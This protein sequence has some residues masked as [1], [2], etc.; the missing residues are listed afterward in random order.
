MRRWIIGGLTCMLLAASMP[1]LA[2]T[3][4]VPVVKNGEIDNVDYDTQLWVSNEGLEGRNFISLFIE[5]NADGTDR[6]DGEYDERI[7]VPRLATVLVQEVAAPGAVGLLEL[8]TAPQLAVQARIIS[9]FQQNRRLGVSLP[10]ISSDN[11][12]EAGGMIRLEPLTRI[13]S[14]H[15]DF[16]V[17]NLGLETAQCTVSFFQ[18]NGSPLG[19][20]AVINVNPRSL[21]EFPDVLGI[22]GAE[23]LGGARSEVSCSEGF[24]AF[25]VTT[26]SSDGDV[27]VVLPSALGSSTLSRP[28]EIPDPTACVEGAD[29]FIIDGMFYRATASD[30]KRTLTVPVTK[31]TEFRR[32]YIEFDFKHGGWFPSLPDG[33]HNIL[34]LTRTG[35]YSSHT[36]CFITT[37]GPNRNFVRNEV[38]VDLPRGENLK[39]SAAVQL[40]PGATYHVRYI[41]DAETGQIETFVFEK[42]TGRQVAG[43][44]QNV[45]RRVR[46]GNQ[47]WQLTFSDNRVE[48]HV[49]SLGWEWSNL[50]LQF[51][52]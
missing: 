52:P 1:A 38:T 39:A 19:A 17:V 6:E 40:Q 23:A 44:V 2:G 10:V 24:Y 12:V 51:Q 18:A 26:D 28:D 27:S 50:N 47:D 30:N 14:R 16:Y 45:A 36:Y 13:G 25:A 29:C 20:N 22:L 48:A 37:R 8:T 4:Y 49:P 31:N 15:S 46:T 33:I 34:Y 21:R 35:G 7:G 43:I 3:V 32:L 41:Y 42:S 9:T 11:L 5:E